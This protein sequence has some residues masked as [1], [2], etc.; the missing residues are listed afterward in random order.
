MIIKV[1]KNNFLL[2]TSRVK[3]KVIRNKYDT[4]TQ[5]QVAA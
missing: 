2:G 5:I 1:G 3:F 4:S